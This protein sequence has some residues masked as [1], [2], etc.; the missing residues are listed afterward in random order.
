MFRS[1]ALAASVFAFVIAACAPLTALSQSYPVKTVRI[2]V[3]FPPGSGVDITTRLVMPKLIEAFGQQFIAD[4]RPGAA[5]NIGAEIA[6]RAPADGYTLF[7]GGAPA[8]ISQSLYPR[9]NYNLVRDFEPIAF[10]ASV[11]FVLV[12]HPSLPVRTVRDL[13]AFAKA[14]RGQLTYASTGSGSTPHLT[15]EMLRERTGIDIVHIPYKGT[16]PAVVDLVSGNVTF[17]FANALSVLSHV[18]SGRLRALAVTSATRSAAMPDLP[19][20]AESYPGLESSTWFALFAPAG[21]P[22]EIVTRINAAVTKTVQ[23]PD[24]RDKFRAQGAETHTGT[25]GELAAYV[26]SEVAKWGKV[27]K[28][29]GAKVE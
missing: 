6:A 11:P 26:R 18:Q 17:M 4:N 14:R 15:A 8:A 29:S 10:M 7:S 25:P 19:A 20:L 22:R 24:V 1:L 28:A 21:T 2:I 3:P 13:V 23:L 27:I 12:V 9:L 5:G 16:P